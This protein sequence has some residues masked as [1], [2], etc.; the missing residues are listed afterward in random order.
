MKKNLFWILLSVLFCACSEQN[1][2]GEYFLRGQ[3]VKYDSANGDLW[4][5][6]M[7]GDVI[8]AR[9]PDMNHYIGKIAKDEWQNPEKLNMEEADGLFFTQGNSGELLILNHASREKE[10]GNLLS[11]TKVSIF[12]CK[13]SISLSSLFPYLTE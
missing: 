13:K 5:E 4:P 6:Y 1:V 12:F 8:V 10:S 7:S 9:S 3:E 11:L 2:D